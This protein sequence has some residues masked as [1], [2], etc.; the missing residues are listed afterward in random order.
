MRR[1]KNGRI[2]FIQDIHFIDKAFGRVVGDQ[3][4][5]QQGII[6]L[7]LLIAGRQQ[8]Q[9]PGFGLADADALAVQGFVQLPAAAVSIFFRALSAGQ[10][11]GG[12]SGKADADVNFRLQAGLHDVL[13]QHHQPGGAQV[14]AAGSEP[15]QGLIAEAQN[16]GFA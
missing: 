15:G 4:Q 6:A 7:R 16:A 13:V 2:V 1:L 11:R 5:A 12:F 9:L 8:L 3:R 10:Q 14:L